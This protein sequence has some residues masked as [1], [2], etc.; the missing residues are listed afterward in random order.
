MA[1]PT[2]ATTADARLWADGDY[3]LG[4]GPR[5][6]DGRLVFVDIL[7]G[8]LFDAGADGAVQRVLW[9][10]DQPLGA[11][12]PVR[13]TPG[14]WIAAVGTG[15]AVITPGGRLDWL[16]RPE[17]TAA[18]P[19]RMNDGSCDPRGRFWAG[20]MAYDAAPKRGS[21]YRVDTDRT[22]HRVLTGMTVVNG[23]A[24]TSDGAVM[25]VA[26]SA[27]AVI[28]R[29]AV[30]DRGALSD[31]HQ[32]V[33]LADG[34]PDGMTVDRESCLWV[35]V[36]G[37]GEVHRY[38][39]NGTLDTVVRLPVTQPTAVCLHP[40]D[41]RLFITSARHGLGETGTNDGAVFCAA[42]RASAPPAASFGPVA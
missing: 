41:G 23:P 34:S 36:W 38:R 4:E 28:H 20:S 8:R 30:D 32:F 29:Y 31:G 21:L 12:A 24:F 40:D 16:A 14:T 39:P 11:V 27:A 25:Y 19:T 3:E 33:R 6:V 22:V 7:S 15:I 17:A 5:W 26:D 35:A 13:G 1:G 18:V 9:H 2:P 10:G 37:R 42:T